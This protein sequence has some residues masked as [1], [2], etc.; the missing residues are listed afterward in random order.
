MVDLAP[1]RFWHYQKGHE[2]KMT[3]HLSQPELDDVRNNELN[4][5]DKFPNEQV[6]DLSEKVVP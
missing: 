6:M 5:K 3:D 2:N 4:I 1:T